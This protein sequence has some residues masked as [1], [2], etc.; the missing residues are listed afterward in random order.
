MMHN[1]SS[2]RRN[3]WPDAIGK[4]DADVDVNGTSKVG[5]VSSL[6]LEPAF[7]YVEEVDAPSNIKFETCSVV[8]SDVEES[9]ACESGHNERKLSFQS[10]SSACDKI[11]DGKGN[12]VRSGSYPTLNLLGSS[13][14]LNSIDRNGN[15]SS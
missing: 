7:C 14:F 2:S 5:R 10:S 9:M 11:I 3:S 4:G 6:A 12:M 15:F 1:K 8:S 13:V